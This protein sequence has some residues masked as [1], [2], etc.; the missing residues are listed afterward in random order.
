MLKEHI[1]RL[2]DALKIVSI[3]KNIENQEILKII[4][5]DNIKNK[6]LKITIT[7]ENNI[8]SLR[9]LPYKEEQYKVGYTLGITKVIKNSTSPLVNIKSTCYYENLII[10][11]EGL[12]NGFNE[13]LQLNEKGCITEGTNSNLFFVKNGII[14]TPN[15]KCGL[16]NGIMRKWIINNFEVH[17]GEYT[18][19]DLYDSDEIFITN[20]LMGVL[21]ISE[22]ESKKYIKGTKTNDIINKYNRFLSTYGG[23]IDG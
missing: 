6:V 14:N 13:M 3:K 18:K 7:E 11:N 8:I 5:E 1:E 4:G 9:E 23:K 15:L 2:N 17:E 22:I 10:K 19:E 12:K 16:L 20:S 21:W